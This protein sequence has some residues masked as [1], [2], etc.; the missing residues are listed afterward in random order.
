MHT[1]AR[2]FLPVTVTEYSNIHRDIFIID[3]CRGQWKCETSKAL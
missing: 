1:Y 3:V 2:L